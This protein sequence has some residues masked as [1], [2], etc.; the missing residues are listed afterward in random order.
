MCRAINSIREFE[1]HSVITD[2]NTEL[3]LGL[4]QHLNDSSS[5]SHKNSGTTPSVCL[6]L[7][8]MVRD[9]LLRSFPNGWSVTDGEIID[10]YVIDTV[11]S[12]R[13]SRK[14]PILRVQIAIWRTGSIS[15]PSH[16]LL[17]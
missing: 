2:S 16:R 3:V 11:L 14:W 13:H 4:S 12:W 10:L 7:L 15:F 8:D 17:S 9:S 6:S 1:G 5:F